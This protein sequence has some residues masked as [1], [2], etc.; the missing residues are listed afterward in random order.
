[1]TRGWRRINRQGRKTQAI[2]P[3]VTRSAIYHNS[4]PQFDLERCGGSLKQRVAK[5]LAS[6]VQCGSRLDHPPPL[7]A[8]SRKCQTIAFFVASLSRLVS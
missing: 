7:L 5:R 2:L 3:T 8:E 1:M 4:Q 6:V